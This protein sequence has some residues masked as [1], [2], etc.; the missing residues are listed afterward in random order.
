MHDVDGRQRMDMEVA[1]LP[2]PVQAGVSEHVASGRRR[3]TN[4][5]DE[6][7]STLPVWS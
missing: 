5:D 4:N 1:P 2:K 6:Q 7:W 3:R